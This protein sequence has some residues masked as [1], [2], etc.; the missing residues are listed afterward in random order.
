M[1]QFNIK[2]YNLFF[3]M[4]IPNVVYI[5]VPY[6]HHWISGLVQCFCTIC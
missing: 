4:L 2:N 1:N 6:S 3:K 5:I